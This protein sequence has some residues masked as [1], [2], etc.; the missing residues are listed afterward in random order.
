VKI[1]NPFREQWRALGDFALT[2]LDNL[3]S[4]LQGA[5]KVEHTDDDR[6]G[7]V[8]A[9]TLQVGRMSFSTILTAEAF[10]VS[11][12]NNFNDSRLRDAGLLRVNASGLSEVSLTG[13][14]VPQDENG[15]VLDGRVLAIENISQSAI[16]A[17]EQEDTQS[18][19][20]NRFSIPFVSGT[21]PTVISRYFL[22]PNTVTLIVYDA[23][24]ARWK[25]FSRTNDEIMGYYEFG[26]NQNDLNFSGWRPC[27]VARLVP[28]AANLT[29]SGFLE[30]SIPVP[31]RKTIIN[32]GTYRF[33]IL[34][35]NTASA[36]ASRV[37]CPGGTMY[38]VNPRESV[39][40]YRETDGTWHINL[41]ADQ[42]TDVAYN[43]AN[44]TADVGTWGVDAADQ[45][46]LAYQID[47]NMMTVSFRLLSTDVSAAPAVLSIPIP[48]GRVAA[49][50]MRNVITVTDAG[51]FGFGFAEVVAG[52]TAI[53]FS[54][55]AGAAYTA[56]AADNTN[57][58]GQITFMVET[59]CATV[60]EPHT[61][62]AH[63]DT[64]HA[65]GGHSDVA[66]VDTAHVDAH[67]DTAHSDAGH[68]D[69]AHADVAHSD[70][71]HSDTA[72]VDGAHQD[73]HS[74]VAHA[75]DPGHNDTHT[76]FTDSFTDGVTHSDR[77]HE[78]SHTDSA[79]HDDT[80][81]A[82][83]HSDSAHGDSA[84]SDTA[85]SDTAHSD[86]AHSDSAHSD[87]AFAD[88][89][90]DT[91]HSDT[92]HADSTHTD[93]AHADSAHIDVG[94]HCDTAHADV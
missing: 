4:S 85:F 11:P 83:S 25:V 93:T 84:H 76:D 73:S 44:F 59:S 3:I 15:A 13:I 7:H 28:T 54:K 6:H 52:Q 17:L 48:A 5:W 78:D 71:A 41:K 23:A 74:D 56:T 55:A 33:A 47:G 70:V 50:W 69:T 60:S 63:G 67:T 20:A 80:A 21:A 53:N 64:A 19:P 29:I 77:A 39:E 57:I 88:S 2:T 8:H 22:L 75:D 94:L 42:W 35:M 43:A 65:D 46:T 68:G 87:T 37:Q 27:R 14:Q 79:V 66:H 86:V 9:T 40:L 12:V 31:S 51:V 91:P 32:E 81:H 38:Y 16:I 61:D 36:A 26:A 82:D 45:V 90:S 72:H 49:R 34:H 18:S 89:H 92:A 62:T 1:G 10:G 24:L 30:T 58:I